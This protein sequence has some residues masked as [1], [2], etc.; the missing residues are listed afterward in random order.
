MLS[1]FCC[2]KNSEENNKTAST[3]SAPLEI[4]DWKDTVVFVP[5]ITGGIVIKVY[6]GDTITIA[7]KLPYDESKLY[8][9]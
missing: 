6:D 5:P 8:R 2:F 7:S 4:P 9:L 3:A 1:L